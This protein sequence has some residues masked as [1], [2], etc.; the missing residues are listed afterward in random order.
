MPVT[1]PR[2]QPNQARRRSNEDHR[3][4]VARQR[5][6]RM[7]AHLLHSVLSVWSASGR[8]EIAVID[9]VVR[10]AGVSRGTFYK[11]FDS[12][13]EA[14]SELSQQLAEEMTS[15]VASVYD[16]LTEP[17]LR[18]ATGFQLF[19]IRAALEPKW[20]AFITRIGLL[21]E[22]NL[23]SSKIHYDIESGAKSGD[24]VVESVDASVDL[25]VGAKVE[26]IL[27]IISGQGSSAYIQIMT[28]MVLRSLG[29]PPAKAD[30]A[31]RTT[32]K[33]LQVEAPGKLPWWGLLAS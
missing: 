3:V 23:L 6:E 8:G 17:L 26:A 12:L 1:K 32:F 2:L 20:G 33:R 18:A 14:V 15:G 9:D 28:A 19:L 31:V 16:V 4:R 21:S 25:L 24:F 22:K 27:R 5:R 13:D 7:R 30:K 11:Y 29:V 10:H